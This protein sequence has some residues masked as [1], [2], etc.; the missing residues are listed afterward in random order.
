MLF[1]CRA[2][3]Q[4][5]GWNEHGVRWASS[6]CLPLVLVLWHYGLGSSHEFDGAFLGVPQHWLSN[7]SLPSAR[8]SLTQEL[9]VKGADEAS[10]TWAR[11]RDAG[12][13]AGARFI[14]WQTP[15]LQTGRLLS[16]GR[17]WRV[18]EL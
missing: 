3:R 8:G 11:G 12:I 4:T 7:F 13:S 17:V 10:I 5:Q 16:V 15:F 2:Y 14:C 18:Q 1:D 6:S 9:L